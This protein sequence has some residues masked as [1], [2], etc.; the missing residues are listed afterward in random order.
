MN[1]T[2]HYMVT[3]KIDGKNIRNLRFLVLNEGRR[4]VIFACLIFLQIYTC[5]AIVRSTEAVMVLLLAG[6]TVVL[7]SVS[8]VISILRGIEY[9]IRRKIGNSVKGNLYQSATD[10]SLIQKIFSGEIKKKEYD[11]EYTIEFLDQHYIIYYENQNQPMIEPYSG[12]R[13][14]LE[15]DEYIYI[16]T[17]RLI[18][19]P[20]RKA[21]LDGE[22]RN[23]LSFLKQK[24]ASI[25]LERKMYSINKVTG[26]EKYFKQNQGDEPK[27]Y[28]AKEVYWGLAG[29][30]IELYF[31][32]LAIGIA[33]E[34][35][36]IS[37]GILILLSIILWIPQR[38]Y[39]EK[40]NQLFGSFLK[41]KGIFMILLY[42]LLFIFTSQLQY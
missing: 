31:I 22:F 20:I 1:H 35:G 9:R 19:Y 27:S 33:V 32:L 8:L 41:K 38:G 11:L 23:W 15:V 42:M 40:L 4:I 28:K 16:C 36:N 30:L 34:V 39:Q 7:I 5:L 6:V 25:F 37:N 2:G 18:A 12:I 29:K 24:K 26:M 17:T 10:L 14:I 13:F 21:D 3:G